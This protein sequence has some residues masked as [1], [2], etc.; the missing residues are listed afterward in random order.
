MEKWEIMLNKLIE[1]P[2][3][4]EQLNRAREIVSIL[5]KLYK[6]P[7]DKNKNILNIKNRYDFS[8]DEL[9]GSCQRYIYGQFQDSILY[10]CFSVEMGLIGK[11]DEV[12]DDNE[13]NKIMDDKKPMA[14]FNLIDKSLEKNIL[15]DK[16]KQFVYE[17]LEMRNIHIHAVN[18][19][20]PLI[21]SY[22]KISKNVDQSILDKDVF[23]EKLKMFNKFIPGFDNEIQKIYNIDDI[24]QAYKSVNELPTFRWAANQNY[25]KLIEDEVEK[26]MIN[27]T[28]ALLSGNSEIINDLFNSYVLRKRS[29]QALELAEK[30]LTEIEIL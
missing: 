16:N 11:L 12:L 1:H 14:L 23:E 7:Y 18:L 20:S 25:M 5:D 8:R 24:I 28:S 17:L 19:I 13:K 22:Q 26:I 10:S 2:I 9:R 29:F 6:Y 3:K 4:E 27:M 30:I 15:N 21:T